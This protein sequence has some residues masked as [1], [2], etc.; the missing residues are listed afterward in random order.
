VITTEKCIAGLELIKKDENGIIVRADDPEELKN[1]IDFLG[2][3]QELRKRMGTNNIRLIKEYT[4]EKMANVFE[5]ILL[6][7]M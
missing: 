1:A 5:K 7:N 6:D 3:N 2:V 4:I